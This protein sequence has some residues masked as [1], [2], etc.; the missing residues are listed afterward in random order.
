LRRDELER[1]RRRTPQVSAAE[2]VLAHLKK[3]CRGVRE[4]LAEARLHEVWLSAGPIRPGIR[5][6]FF[7]GIFS[8]GNTA[9]EAHP[10]I[11]EG[12]GMAMQ[13]AW[14]LCG[15]LVARQSHSLSSEALRE[16]G[17]DYSK[18]WQKNFAPRIRAAA[19]FAHLAIKPSAVE[20]LLPLFR[21]FPSTLTLGARWSGKAGDAMALPGQLSPNRPVG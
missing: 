19:L 16:I 12:I 9:G 3:S 17:R 6:R 11:A 21:L 14:L 4:S 18:A 1:C 7:G 15:H 5:P 10:I 2:A 20:L 13:S 8:A